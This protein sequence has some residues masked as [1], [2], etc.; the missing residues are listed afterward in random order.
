M[1]ALLSVGLHH[2]AKK[3]GHILYPGAL[4]ERGITLEI[5][6]F[7]HFE[8]LIFNVLAAICVCVWVGMGWSRVVS[9]VY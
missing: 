2:A 4:W 5:L 6:L 9:Y 8:L 3:R 1:D 7:I